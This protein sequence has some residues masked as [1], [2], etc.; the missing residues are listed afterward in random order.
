MLKTTLTVSFEFAASHRLFRPELSDQ[1]N[2]TLFGKCANPHGH[3][4]N[5][6]LEVRVGGQIEPR[7]GMVIDASRLKA[8]VEEVVL[9]DVDHKDL[10]RDTPWMKGKIPSSEILAQAI[11]E[12][13]STA[14]AKECS[15]AWLDSI[16]LHE[17]RRISVTVSRDQR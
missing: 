9:A 16:T 13:L 7:S 5:Y 10:N 2:T 11:F 14:V 12:R 3:G 8:I 17:T 6:T 4:H 15:T 1:E